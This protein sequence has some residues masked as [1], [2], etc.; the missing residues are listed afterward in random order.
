MK[1]CPE[2]GLAKNPETGL[3]L[4]LGADAFGSTTKTIAIIEIVIRNQIL[5][6][7]FMA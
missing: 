1:F 4:E 5:S 7:I 6:Y 2:L 3:R